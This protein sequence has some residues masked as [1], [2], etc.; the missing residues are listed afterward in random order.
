MEQNIKIRK[1]RTNDVEMV[2]ALATQLS[3][4]VTIKKELLEKNFQKLV[5]DKNHQILIAEFENAIVGYLSGYL[6]LTIYANGK[7][8]YVDEIVVDTNNRGTGV[9]K[10]LMLEFERISKTN[11]CVLISLATSKARGFYENLAYF[12][13]A[14]YY[15]KYLH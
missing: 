5:L 6:H 4:S 3:R 9:G 7:T 12:S 13:K 2:Y 15:K 11:D 1:A 10:K 8:A 14:A